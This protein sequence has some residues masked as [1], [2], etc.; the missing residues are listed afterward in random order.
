MGK[1][2]M[3]TFARV[4]QCRIGIEHIDLVISFVSHQGVP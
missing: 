4:G 2:S 3:R 1:C